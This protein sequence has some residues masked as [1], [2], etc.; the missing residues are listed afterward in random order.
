MSNDENIDPLDIETV[1]V[2]DLIRQEN[3]GKH[4]LI[5]V[6]GVSIGLPRLPMNLSLAWWILAKPNRKGEFRA[7]IRIVGPHDAV[8]MNGELLVNI[9][10]IE[11]NFV[12]RLDTPIQIQSEGTLRFQIQFKEPEWKT[13][14]EID[15][16]KRAP[17][18]LSFTIAAS[19]HQPQA[20]SHQQSQDNEVQG[21]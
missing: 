18:P 13:I 7:Q 9:K 17:K 5:G 12:L 1:V 11:K 21:S 8:L 15:V 19:A 3:N 16:V 14:K 6:Y 4:L 10:E 20:G 2:C